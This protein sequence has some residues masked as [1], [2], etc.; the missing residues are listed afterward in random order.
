SDGGELRSRMVEIEEIG[1]SDAA[2]A[3]PP[4][5]LSSTENSPQPASEASGQLPPVKEELN[6]KV[7]C[8]LYAVGVALSLLFAAL[9]LIWKVS[10]VQGCWI[11]FAPFA[12]C[13]LYAMYR[14]RLQV[15]AAKT[16]AD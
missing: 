14:C 11:I 3:P 9:Q 8:L 15:R 13:L 2:P 16:K 10:A 7:V 1:S 12:P 4:L 6:W 5:P